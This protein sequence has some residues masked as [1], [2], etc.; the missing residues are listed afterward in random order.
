MIEG[1]GDVAV[2]GMASLFPGAPHLRTNWQKNMGMVD[3]VS[4]PP[5]DWGPEEIFRPD[6]AANDRIYCRRGGFL[7]DLARFDPLEHGV[8]PAAVD[9]GEPEHFLA[10]RLASQAL[11]DAGYDH[12]PFARERTAVIL[13]RSTFLNRGNATAFQHGLVVDQTIGILRQLHPEYEEREL[14]EIRSALKAA[15]PPFTAETAPAL[16]S[17]VMCGRIANRLDLRGPS[18]AVDAA[19]A[20]SLIA[21]DA[22]VEALRSGRC[23]LALVGGV[24]VSS[25]PI[26]FMVFCQ[27]GALSRRGELRPFDA[28]ADGTLLGE[29]VGVVVLKRLSDAE[30]DGD[31]IY[32]VV[33]GTGVA[34]DGRGL[35]VLAPRVEGEEL[36]LR[37][38]YE[39]AAIDPATV[40]LIEA[41]GTGTVVGDRTEIEA[42]GR[43]FGPRDRRPRCAIGSVKSMISHTIPAAGIAG[44]IKATLALHNKVLPPTL[45]CEHVHAG[46]GIERTPFYVSTEPRPWIQGSLRPRRAGV[47]AFGFGGINAHVVLEEHGA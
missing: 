10:L 43:V 25:P 12:R 5:D 31:R 27:L 3:A 24:H 19:C 46:L 33:R 6:S 16:V 32:A 37:R 26:V 44:L 17:N 18:Y 22:G 30:R 35:G 40:G 13:G 42:L 15:L 9:G 14:A 41:H 29:G 20:S 4:D 8:M 1:R 23:D 2:I 45:H 39:D 28:D 21:V 7:K 38:A 47:N 36:A 11:A 34:S